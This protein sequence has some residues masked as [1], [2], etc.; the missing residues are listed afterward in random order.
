MV[1][2]NLLLLMWFWGVL[3][4]ALWIDLLIIKRRYAID[5]LDFVSRYYPHE[6]S[7]AATLLLV[8]CT[9]LVN[10]FISRKSSISPKWMDL[11]SIF[12]L[13]LKSTWLYHSVFIEGDIWKQLL[14]I[15]VLSPLAM[16]SQSICP[17]TGRAVVI[18][19]TCSLWWTISCEWSS[20]IHL[21][22]CPYFIP[23]LF[24]VWTHEYV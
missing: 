15:I 19:E 5:F 17:L 18:S 9:L 2:H 24:V 11:S 8:R 12:L 3:T 21:K 14:H 6:V 7:R 16:H 10:S 23:I 4:A 22:T 13:F 1:S 20:L